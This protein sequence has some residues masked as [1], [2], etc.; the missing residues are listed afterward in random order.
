[1]SRTTPA[2]RKL[3]SAQTAVLAVL[4]L[5]LLGLAATFASLNAQFLTTRNAMNLLKHMSVIALA[6][7]GL[8]F[9]IAVGQADMSFHFVSCFAGM[10]MSYLIAQGQGPLAAIGV[11]CA[12]AAGFGLVNGLLVGRFKLP[13][14]VATIGLGTIAWGLAYF[15][16]EGSHIFTNFD[17]SGIK[18]L[19]NA[20]VQGVPLPILLMGAAYL[21][22]YLLLH[23]SKHGRRLQ[24]IGSNPIAARFSGV[25]VG[26]Y[27]T[28]AFVLCAVL[29]ALTNMIQIAAQG[30][31]NVKGG[32][33]L[34]MPAYATVFV[35]V[36]VF[37]KPTVGGTF[38][39]ALLIGLVQNGFTL[40]G[41]KF[42]YM[43]FVIGVVLMAAIAISA[44]DFPKLGAAL[45]R[46][47]RPAGREDAP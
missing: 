46:R 47:I 13:D 36:S 24:A 14:M 37:K 11:G 44:I 42:Y 15:Y 23:R 3:L 26:W 27:V 32:L 19:N 18:K 30:N 20:R 43:E 6:G 45:A 21:L 10:T 35:G 31:G 7:L 8:T 4:C 5:L 9:V 41:K 1:M 34:L 29:A 22:G 33:N 17:T 39:G 2:R 16:S 12:A 25:R 38:L 28:G 40:L